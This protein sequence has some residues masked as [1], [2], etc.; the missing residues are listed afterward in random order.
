MNS[1]SQKHKDDR[2]KRIQ[3]CGVK[4]NHRE[5]DESNLPFGPQSPRSKARTRPYNEVVKP[6]YDEYPYR[7]SFQRRDL[8]SLSAMTISLKPR[9]IFSSRNRRESI[10]SCTSFSL[11]WRM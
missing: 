6:N 7:K 8:L 2:G 3:H 11:S 10:N 5:L 1:F 4:M 9:S